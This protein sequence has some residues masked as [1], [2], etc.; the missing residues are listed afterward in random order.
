M[1]ETMWSQMIEHIK[2]LFLD[3]VSSET[4]N[5]KWKEISLQVPDWQLIHCE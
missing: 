3:R 5:K 2:E 4:E 1:A